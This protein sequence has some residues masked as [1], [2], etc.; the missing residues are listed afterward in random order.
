MRSYQQYCPAARA[1][2]LVGERWT[3]LIVRDLLAGP[4]RY[5]DLQEGL[6]GIGPNVLAQRLRSLEGAAIVG[7]RRLAPPAASTVYELTELG[8]GLRP[9]LTELFSWGLQVLGHPGNEDAVKASWWLPAVESA[10]RQAS[11]PT[12]LEDTYEMRIGDEVMTLRAHAGEVLIREGP[13]DK[14]DVKVRMDH[15]TLALLGRRQISPLQAVETG[16]MTVDG[17]PAA[18]ERCAALF[19]LFSA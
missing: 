13:A 11:V 14:P 16:R 17:D 3:L 10:L 5:T 6:P 19:G 4:K 1:L 18:A 12:D 15:E 7:R 2:D 8:S 9:V